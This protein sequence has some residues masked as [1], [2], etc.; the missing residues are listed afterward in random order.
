MIIMPKKNSLSSLCIS[1]QTLP[2]WNFFVTRLINFL[3]V[4]SKSYFN[5]T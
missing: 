2:R 5:Y 1:D 4:L 3:L